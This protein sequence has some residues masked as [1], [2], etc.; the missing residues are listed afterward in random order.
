MEA[1]QAER[2]AQEEQDFSSPVVLTGHQAN[3]KRVPVAAGSTALGMSWLPA[4]PR[5]SLPM[6]FYKHYT[7]V[8]NTPE[9]AQVNSAWINF[10]LGPCSRERTYSRREHGSHQRRR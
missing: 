7:S 2:L 4:P 5:F 3:I 1:V 6:K 8:P 9:I 10:I